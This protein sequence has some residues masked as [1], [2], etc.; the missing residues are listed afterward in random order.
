MIT[1]TEFRDLVID[2]LNRTG[3][4]YGLDMESGFR[5]FRQEIGQ[6]G[7]LFSLPTSSRQY[8]YCPKDGWYYSGPASQGRGA[9]LQEA[10]AQAQQEP[11]NA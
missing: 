10:I 8:S 11:V 9:T 5:N 2:D 3:Q 7:Y 4:P 1:Y 6:G